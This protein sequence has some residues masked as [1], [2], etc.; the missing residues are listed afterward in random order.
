[1]VLKSLSIQILVLIYLMF[2]ASNGISGIY[3]LTPTPTEAVI[4]WELQELLTNEECKLPCLWGLNVGQNTKQHVQ[5]LVEERLSVDSSDYWDANTR[6]HITY[7]WIESNAYGIVGNFNFAGDS[8]TSI[9]LHLYD[10]KRWLPTDTFELEHI[11]EN[12]E[13]V[14]DVYIAI[15]PISVV[16]FRIL[17][18]NNELGVMLEYVFELSDTH[19]LMVSETPVFCPQAEKIREISIWIQRVDKNSLVEDLLYPQ[20]PERLR[21]GDFYKPQDFFTN[22]DIETFSDQIT[23]ITNGCIELISAAEMNEMGY[24]RI[25]S[26]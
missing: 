9:I 18:I 19:N 1:V 2:T 6:L 21:S 12:Q 7:N 10:P 5:M 16:E 24:T 26:R 11:L 17:I 3:N 22:L 4:P 20:A 15:N 8:L 23:N 25:Y 13:L 14:Q